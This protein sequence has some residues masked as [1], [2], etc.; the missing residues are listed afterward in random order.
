MAEEKTISKERWLSFLNSLHDQLRDAK[1]IKLT[2][3]PA[4]NELSNFLMLYF[5]DKPMGNKESSLVEEHNLPRKCS[6]EWLYEKYATKEI[7][8]EDY[9]RKSRF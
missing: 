8:K 1:S 5:I 3:I 2:G 6:F 4:L 9:E 7:I